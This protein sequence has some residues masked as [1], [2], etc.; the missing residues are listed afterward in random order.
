MTDEVQFGIWV[1]PSLMEALLPKDI[2]KH[3][4]IAIY[5]NKVVLGCKDSVFA[6]I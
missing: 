3:T 5:T 6:G 4:L 2:L 1:L